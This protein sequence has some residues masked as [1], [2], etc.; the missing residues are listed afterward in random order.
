M[1]SIWKEFYE[2]VHI[3]GDASGVCQL[4]IMKIKRDFRFAG[5]CERWK[6]NLASFENVSA[7]ICTSNDFGSCRAPSLRIYWISFAKFAWTAQTPNSWTV[8][9]IVAFVLM[10]WVHTIDFRSVVRW[11]TFLASQLL[12]L[13]AVTMQL[14]PCNSLHR[15]HDVGDSII[16]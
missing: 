6:L 4:K 8:T 3:S 1:K 10:H 13:F 12:L 11:N 16:V 15:W 9:T 14:Y 5:N 2:A 7:F